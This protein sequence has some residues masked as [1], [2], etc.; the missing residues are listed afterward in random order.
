[1]RTK[2]AWKVPFRRRTE[3]KVRMMC[4]EASGEDRQTLEAA[5]DDILL[6]K[7]NDVRIEK[8][9]S[10]VE[11]K[12]VLESWEKLMR[13]ARIKES[14]EQEEEKELM[15]NVTKVCVFG[16]GSFGTA[17]G[18][19]LARKK[20]QLKVVLLLRDENTCTN[21][22]YSH[23][24]SK[25]LP[26]YDLPD[27]VHATT[28]PTAALQDADFVIHAIPVQSST[29]FLAAIKD[30]IPEDLPILAVSKGLEVGTGKMM[31]EV[32][33]DA[34]G[35]DQPVVFLSGPSFAV[36]MMQ[37]RPTTVVAASKDPQLARTA[38]LLFACPYLRVNTSSDVIGVEVA[39]ALKNVLAIAAGVVEGLDLGNNALAALTAQGC[40]EIRWLSRKMGAKSAT[41]QGAAGVGDIMLTCFVNLSR[42]RTVGVRLGKGE[43]IEEILAS[44][45]QVAEGVAT[46]GVVV[47]LASRYK[48]ALP[49]L[50]A[51]ARIIAGQLSPREA[52]YGIMNLPQ[53]EER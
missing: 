44:S 29:T 38:Q 36:E 9:R 39:G 26:D 2:E 13:W 17:M 10:S 21:I 31:S 48:V 20:S 53:I 42:N 11:D 33:P 52:V 41:L 50:T 32:I 5:M 22:N 4:K 19:L 16:G 14:K 7:S 28:D 3:R 45:T 25:Y 35:R 6:R 46:A 37:K 34:L 43:S 49:V 40:S 23:R 24:N 8:I 51:V 47:H 15:E 27:N 1:M 12:Q 18:T 30:I